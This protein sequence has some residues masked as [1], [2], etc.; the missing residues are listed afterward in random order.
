MAVRIVIDLQDDG[1]VTINGPLENKILCY[2]L[3]EWGKMLVKDYEPSKIIKDTLVPPS[4]M[5]TP[6]RSN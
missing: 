6:I 1:K 4:N 5:V 2:G 3:L